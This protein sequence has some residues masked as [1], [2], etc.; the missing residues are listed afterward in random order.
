MPSPTLLTLHRQAIRA[1]DTLYVSG[2]IGLDPKVLLG[3]FSSRTSGRIKVYSVD[4]Q[5]GF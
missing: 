3:L 2:Q 1:G 4:G 5:H